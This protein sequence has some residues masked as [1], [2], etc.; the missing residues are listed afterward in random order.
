MSRQVDAVSLLN[1]LEVLV[2]QQ[3]SE[4]VAKYQNLSTGDLSRPA[5]DGGWSVA[6]CFWHLNSY[7]NYY[8][9]AIEKGLSEKHIMYNSFS[10][11]WLGSWFTR[12]MQPGP[13]MKKMKAF[14][15][16]RPPQEV[17]PHAAVAE[18]IQQQEKL[19]MLLRQARTSDLNRVRIGISIL[20]WVKMRLG[21]VFQFLIVHQE[22]H[23]QQAARVLG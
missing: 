4:V 23:L 14:K 1:K 9:P 12:S 3:I 7:G 18:F 2:E 6:E 21:D 8:L 19:L 22:R 15:D 17:N 16:H 20:S 11:T 10:S 5:A 13:Q